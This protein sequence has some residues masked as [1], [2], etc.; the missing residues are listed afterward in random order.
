[1]TPFYFQKTRFGFSHCVC[2][3]LERDLTSSK[4]NDSPGTSGRRKSGS[5]VSIDDMK[6]LPVCRFHEAPFILVV[7]PKIQFVYTKPTEK[8]FYKT[9]FRPVEEFRSRFGVHK[10]D[11]R[12]Y[13]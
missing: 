13:D 5:L 4:Q 1:M 12:L 7:E 10:W 9:K 6:R 3:D 11:F 8:L 2:M